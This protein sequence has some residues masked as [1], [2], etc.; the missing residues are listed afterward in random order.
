MRPAD[1]EAREEE[2]EVGSPRARSGRAGAWLRSDRRSKGACSC[3]WLD[4]GAS[5]QRVRG[6]R[7]LSAGASA[8]LSLLHRSTLRDGSSQDRTA[9]C[10]NI[11]SS[12]ALGCTGTPLSPSRCRRLSPL[13]DPLQRRLPLRSRPYSPRDAPQSAPTAALSGTARPLLA[14]A[15]APLAEV[16]LHPAPPRSRLWLQRLRL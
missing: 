11:S 2:G 14:L 4:C 9:Q 7:E 5:S 10:A 8:R 3:R 16:G 1:D 13:V 15:S 6:G 12:S